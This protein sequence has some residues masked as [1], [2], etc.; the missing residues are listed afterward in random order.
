MFTTSAGKRCIVAAKM[1]QTCVTVSCSGFELEKLV[2][3][4]YCKTLDFCD[5][6]LSSKHGYP[7]QFGRGTHFPYI[8]SNLNYFVL[9]TLQQTK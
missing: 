7:K 9:T 3:A 6:S 8:L 2:T 1:K 4:T 5:A